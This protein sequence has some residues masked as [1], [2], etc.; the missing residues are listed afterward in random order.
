MSGNEILLT[1]E[2]NCIFILGEILYDTYYTTDSDLNSIGL[3]WLD[4][5]DLFSVTLNSVS[6]TFSLSSVSNSSDAFQENLGCC[7]KVKDTLK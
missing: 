4:K 6:N 3:D 5:L 7:K 1:R 2:L